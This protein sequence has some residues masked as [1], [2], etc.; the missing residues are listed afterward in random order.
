MVWVD[1]AVGQ[2]CGLMASNWLRTG[3]ASSKLGS[4][5][6]G[7]LKKRVRQQDG[8]SDTEGDTR[9]KGPLSMASRVVF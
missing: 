2:R 1:R 5:L 9:N 6:R 7:G 3:Q 8:E 4:R